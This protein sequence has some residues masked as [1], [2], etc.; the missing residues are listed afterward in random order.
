MFISSNRLNQIFEI[1]KEDKKAIFLMAFLTFVV[2]FFDI[3][4]IGLIGQFIGLILNLDN[5]GDITFGLDF[6]EHLKKFDREKIIIISSISLFFIFLF[7]N[8]ISVLIRW[9]IINFTFNQKISIQ[10]N[11]LNFYLNLNMVD[12]FR[13]NTSELT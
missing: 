5:L 4:G 7:K 3:L 9:A 11:L 10:K 1:L 6:Y 8:I 12:F 2:S 13:K